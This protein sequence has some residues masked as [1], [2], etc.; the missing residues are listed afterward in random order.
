MLEWQILPRMPLRLAGLTVSPYAA[1]VFAV[2]YFASMIANGNGVTVF[3][4]LC[5][6]L[7][8]LLEPAL[9]LVG[10]ISL[11]PRRGGSCLT[12]AL[13]LGLIALLFID[14]GSGLALAAFLGAFRILW[15][16]TA[17][18]DKGGK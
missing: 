5:E 4:M 10:F 3:G 1:A 7:S 6:N 14:L 13:A 9:A 11:A 18:R 12:Q 8:L 17:P 15:P 16:R 2:S